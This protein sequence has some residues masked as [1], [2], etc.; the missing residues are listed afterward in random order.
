DRLLEVVCKEHGL[1]EQTLI[2]FGRRN[3]WVQARRQ[4][5][6]LGREWAKMTTQELGE[7]LKRDPSMMSRLYKEYAEN[8]DLGR[9]A[10]LV[11]TLNSKTG[12]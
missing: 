6:Y 9:E 4:L 2:G 10:I 1:A 11:R 3:D 5:V 8:R 12:S 7:R